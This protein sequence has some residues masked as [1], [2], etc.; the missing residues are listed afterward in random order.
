MRHDAAALD[1][2]SRLAKLLND[3]EH[4]SNRIG[5][6]G[7]R[8]QVERGVGAGCVEGHDGAFGIEYGKKVVIMEAIKGGALSALPEEAE[9][10]LKGIRPNDSISSW[11]QRFSLEMEDVIAVLSGM[12]ALQQMEDNIATAKAS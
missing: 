11:S 8:E 4:R 10:I 1:P 12:S 7:S 3:I 9:A 2:S 5:G 6:F